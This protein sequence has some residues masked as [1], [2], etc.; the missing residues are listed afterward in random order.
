MVALSSGVVPAWW[1]ALG[2]GLV[3][4]LVVWALLEALRRSVGQVDEGVQAVWTSGKRVAQNTWT[5]HLFLTTKARGVELLEE[6]ERHAA[7][8]ERSGS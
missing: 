5:A 3:V 8:A 7:A 4:A 1:V 6:V 2:V